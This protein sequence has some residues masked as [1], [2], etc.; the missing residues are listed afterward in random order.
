MRPVLVLVLVLVQVLV[1]VLVLE[2]ERARELAPVQ[3]WAQ[4]KQ[5]L[6][7]RLHRRRRRLSKL[8][9]WQNQR[10]LGF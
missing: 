9:D 6:D 7:R 2:R 3:G 8:Q 5:A 4:A 1:L 10:H